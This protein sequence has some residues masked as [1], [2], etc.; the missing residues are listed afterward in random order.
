MAQ[1]RSLLLVI[2]IVYLITIGLAG[3][4]D[5]PAKSETIASLPG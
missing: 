3:G 2:T 4:Q 1:L 5:K